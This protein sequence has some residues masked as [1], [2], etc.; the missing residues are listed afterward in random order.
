MNLN[1]FFFM[2]QMA[3]ENAKWLKVYGRLGLAPW[4]EAMIIGSFSIILGALSAGSLE[5]HQ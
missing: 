2:L 5:Y 3:S 1:I 4:Q